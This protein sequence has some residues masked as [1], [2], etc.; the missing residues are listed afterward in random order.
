[1]ADVNYNSV[2]SGLRK[3]FNTGKTKTFRW[4]M[5]Q[6]TALLRLL[7]E[8]TDALNNAL[9]QDL[10]KCVAEAVL[11]EVNYSRNEVITAMSN[12]KEWMEPEWVKKNLFTMMDTCFIKREPLG[13]ALILGAWNY[14]I[15]LTLCPLVGAIAAGNC[16]LLKPSEVSMNTALLLEKLLPKYLDN[17]CL[18]VIN[19]GIPETTALLN[20]RYDYIFYT[21]NT[22]VGKIVYQAAAK[23]LTPV[24]LE[25][26][27]KSPCYIDKETDLDVASNRLAWGKWANA[28]QTCIAPDY[29]LVRPELQDKL[30]GKLKESIKKF[31]G[32]DPKQSNDFA[33]IVN[34]RHVDR[35][36]KFVENGGGSVA[37][38]G[39]ID[40]KARYISPTILKDVKDT[41]AAMQEEIFGPV[42][43]IMPVQNEQEAINF[44]NSREKP[45]AM[46]VFAN[47]KKVAER[48]INATSSGSCVVN[49]C[50]VQG[51][52]ETLPFGGVGHSGIG[53]YHGKFSFETF[54]HKRACMMKELKMEAVNVIRYPPYTEKKTNWAKWLLK[55]PTKKNPVLAWAP[56]LL[57]GVVLA[58]LIKV[59]GLQSYL[60]F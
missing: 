6:L 45:L 48:M 18:K 8:N 14:P 27:G 4:R 20:E 42:L 30:I 41:D 5:D 38:G 28:G 23:H 9:K 39:V 13:V 58:L 50:L 35:V 24:T 49:D 40:E 33:R 1:M 32:D 16:V 11:F 17:D 22:N 56:Y 54:T 36:R 10:N 57:M 2:V 15:Q 52:L 44:I 12:L 19:G 43:P 25:L 55:K 37:H 26:G 46:Y 53:A 31:F 34:S 60:G 47:D 7:D 21:G 51:A 59:L 29:V 3:E